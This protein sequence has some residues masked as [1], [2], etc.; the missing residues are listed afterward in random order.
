[1][2][3]D[4]I[5]IKDIL[6]KEENYMQKASQLNVIRRFKSKGDAV[7]NASLVNDLSAFNAVSE[8]ALEEVN[9][10]RPV[11]NWP[12]ASLELGD[13]FGI[14]SMAW[15]ILHQNGFQRELHL[16]KT[17]IYIQGPPAY[18]DLPSFLH[19]FLDFSPLPEPDANQKAQLQVL[20]EEM[21]FDVQK[22]LKSSKKQLK[23]P[24][25]HKYVNVH[26]EWEWMVKHA[27]IETPFRKT[28]ACE[29]SPEAAFHFCNSW[30]ITPS[31]GLDSND[32]S[33]GNQIW[34]EHHF[35]MGFSHLDAFMDTALV[36]MPFKSFDQRVTVMIYEIAS[37]ISK[38]WLPEDA[39][40]FG[41]DHKNTVGITGSAL[42]AIEACDY[43]INH[44]LPSLNRLNSF[45]QGQ[46]G[47]SQHMGRLNPT[48]TFCDE[49][50]TWIAYKTISPKAAHEIETAWK[51]GKLNKEL[52]QLH[53]KT[54]ALQEK[55]DLMTSQVL[56]YLLPGQP[57]PE[58]K[59]ILECKQK[60]R[61]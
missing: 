12:L 10:Q 27:K 17:I 51:Q 60:L 28:A 58:P 33:F 48:N 43:F 19:H 23:N 2:Y 26:D 35:P 5:L 6:I 39:I 4:N 21:G 42:I 37:K 55:Y 30:L 61:L 45:T 53:F 46:S 32:P 44:V 1:M 18:K 40:R 52:D 50:W 36:H 34:F 41:F 22:I 20:A 49:L 57:T 31:S 38:G 14:E 56:A 15:D 24:L 3:R 25:R 7:M 11:F 59:E 8:E 16:L 54:K 47:L 13:Y 9:Y 29:L